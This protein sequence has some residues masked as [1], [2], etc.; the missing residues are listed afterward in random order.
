MAAGIIEKGS[1]GLFENEVELNGKYATIVRSLKEETGLF[2]TFREAYVAA[3]AIG[4]A[5]HRRA[6]EDV[7]EKVQPASIFKTELDKRKHDLKLLY[8]VIMLA[9][10][11]ADYSIEDY[12]DRAFRDD[13]EHGNA[14]KLKENMALFNMYACGGL[15]YLY[16]KFEASDRQEDIID[17]LYDIV[18]NFAIGIDLIE[19]DELPDFDPAF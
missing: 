9:E 17:A 5:N 12:I 14:E 11:N 16:E 18:H 15:E 2:S 7:S 8:R 6:T 10:D 4:F 1:N 19:E 3:A 13:S